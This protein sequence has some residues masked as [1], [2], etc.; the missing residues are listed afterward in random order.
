MPIPTTLTWKTI[1][2]GFA[3]QWQFSLCTGAIDGKH[4]LMQAPAHSGSMYFNSKRNYS[5]VLMAVAD[6]VYGFVVL[7]VGAQ[8]KHS[9]GSIFA[10]SI[11]GKRLKNDMLDLPPPGTNERLLYAF[12]ADEAFALHKHIMKPY[13]G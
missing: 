13:L 3:N 1:A 11:F 5:M 8:G 7:D 12:F 9:D 6:A 10:N 2:D 4:V